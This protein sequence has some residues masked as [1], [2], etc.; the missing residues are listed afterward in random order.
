MN[1][2]TPAAPLILIGDTDQEAIQHLRTV[3]EG[4]QYPVELLSEGRAVLRRLMEPTPPAIAILDFNLPGLSTTE[5]VAEFRRRTQ[6]HAVWIMLTSRNASSEIIRTASDAGVDDFLQKPIDEL[7]LRVRLRTADRV[8][9]VYSDLHAQMA[10]VR[11]HASHDRLTGLLNREALLT[12][13]FE[14]TDRVQRMKTPLTMLLIDL[15]SFSQ[16]N[17][18]YGYAAGDRILKEL[19]QR[20]KRY[21]RS[22]DLVG[23]CGEDEFLIALPGCSLEEGTSMAERLHRAV[24]QKPFHL[25]RDI[26]PVTASIGLAQSHGRSPL[27]V[28]REAERSLAEAKLSGGNCVRALDQ[29]SALPGKTVEAKPISGHLGPEFR[30]W[31]A[32]KGI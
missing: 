7:D 6:K 8:Q 32:V 16:V 14:E 19:A 30:Q 12:K 2:P 17:A 1:E 25:E 13:L 10:A 26:V 27:V 20:F 22:Y 15:D 28:L 21:L 29:Q 3:L 31:G 5:V 9:S 23:R 4:W 24:L 18:D 11:F